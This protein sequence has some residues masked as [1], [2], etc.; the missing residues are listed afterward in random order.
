MNKLINKITSCE[1]ICR[2]PRAI[3]VKVQSKV[4]EGDVCFNTKNASVSSRKS[5]GKRNAP[6]T[7]PD[8]E[9]PASRVKFESP[10]DWKLPPDLKY[11]KAFPKATLANMP[12]VTIDGKTKPFCNKPFSLQS[13]WNGHRCFFSHANPA[14]FG[15]S[16]EMNKFYSTAYLAAKNA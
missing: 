11:S 13:C 5:N 8:R 15:K 12:M 7:D 6:S 3:L 2:M 9:H 1:D 14:D 10:A 4:R 16:E